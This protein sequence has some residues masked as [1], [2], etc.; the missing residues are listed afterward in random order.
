MPVAD[1][2][3]ETKAPSRRLKGPGPCAAQQIAEDLDG[4]RLDL[5]AHP[6]MSASGG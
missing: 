4:R 1:G 3:T 5:I 2:A 6:T